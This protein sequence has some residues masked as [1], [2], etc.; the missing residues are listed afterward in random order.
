M[1]SSELTVFYWKHSSFNKGCCWSCTSRYHLLTNMKSNLSINHWNLKRM[2]NLSVWP[3]SNCLI[4]EIVQNKTIPEASRPSQYQCD[5]YAASYVVFCNIWPWKEC[6]RNCSKI[7]P[8]HLYP[9]ISAAHHH[10]RSPFSNW[11][12]IEGHLISRP[13]GH[14][15][16]KCSVYIRGSHRERLLKHCMTLTQICFKY[17]GLQLCLLWFSLR[18]QMMGGGIRSASNRSMLLKESQEWCPKPV[19]FILYSGIP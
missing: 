4:W 7:K 14:K 6:C 15:I 16:E 12:G 3:T 8:Y 19:V 13:F 1:V 9:N 11:H 10:L 5:S 18:L 17:K 2:V